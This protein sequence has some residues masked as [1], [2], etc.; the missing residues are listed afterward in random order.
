MSSTKPTKEELV[1]RAS[2]ALMNEV[3]SYFSTSRS[4]KVENVFDDRPTYPLSNVLKMM[5]SDSIAWG[6]VT[7]LVDKTTENGW[8]IRNKKTG[9]RDLETETLLR[10]KGLDLWLRTMITHYAIFQNAFGEVVYGGSGRM[11]ELHVLNPTEVEIFSDEHGEV[12][13]YAQS[14]V[15]NVT[16]GSGA[17]K[18]FPTWKPEEILHVADVGIDMSNWGEVST[19]TLW[20]AVALKYHIKKFMNWLFETNQ[21]RGIYN[22]KGADEQA[23]RRS[24]TYLKESEKNINKPVIFEGEFQYILT[25]DFSDLRTLNDLLYKM[26]EEILNLLQVPP[27]YAGLPDNSNRSNSDAQERA[28]YTRIR[29]VQRLFELHLNQLLTR[30]K[31]F[32]SEFKFN[33]VS[34]K[35]TKEHIE[36]A[37]LMKSISV[38]NEVIADWL[39]D[40][41]VTLPPG[42][43]FEEAPEMMDPSGKEI[44]EQ[45][46]APSRRG[47]ATGD[48]NKRIGTGDEATTREDQLVSRARYKNYWM[49]DA[50]VE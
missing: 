1:E 32:N 37:Q 40:Q 48:G 11:K 50:I 26:D 7:T 5:R 22:I 23:I 2:K 33:P 24:I 31:I 20:E 29:S 13:Y 35:V 36:I 9:E 15:G 16:S 28:F 8:T 43:I 17:D 47:K 38:K 12:L 3:Q 6:A 10:N 44:L 41:G 30:M 14:F 4:R 27:I 19:R 18:Q 46:Q 25:R 49:Y 34:A 45:D 42:E 39:R 21:F